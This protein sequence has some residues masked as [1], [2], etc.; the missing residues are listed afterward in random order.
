MNGVALSD[1]ELEWVKRIWNEMNDVTKVWSDT[2]RADDIAIFFGTTPKH[3]KVH[4]NAVADVDLVSL[5]CVPSEAF[6]EYEDD[7][8]DDD[9]DFAEGEEGY[10]S[11]A[12]GQSY[13]DTYE[14][15]G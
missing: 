6:E 2:A 3:V 1:V 7:D 10:E 14:Y 5:T 12:D 4:L 11:Y 15:T 8:D 13:D 9:D